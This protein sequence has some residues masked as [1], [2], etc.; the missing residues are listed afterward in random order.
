MSV[1]QN[2]IGE[3]SEILSPSAPGLSPLVVPFLFYHRYLSPF[4]G[5]DCPCIPSCSAYA[6]ESFHRFGALVGVLLSIDRLIH[7]S[8]EIVS[9]DILITE[10]RIS[11]YDPLDENI[12]W[13]SSGQN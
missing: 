12:A 1:D 2:L 3:F 4:D 5:R 13:L 10:Q 7:E 9:G 6:L 11:C 8:D